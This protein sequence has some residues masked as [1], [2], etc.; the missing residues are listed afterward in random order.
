MECLTWSRIK[1]ILQQ[2]FNFNKKSHPLVRIGSGIIISSIGAGGISWAIGLDNIPEKYKIFGLIEISLS[3]DSIGTYLSIAGFLVGLL[4][5]IIGLMLIKKGARSTS[6]VLIVSMLGESAHFPDSILQESEKLDIRETIKL[7]L[8]EGENYIEQSIQMFNAEKMVDIYH[9]FILHGDCKKVLLGGRARVPFLVAYGSCFKSISAKVEYFD[10]LHSDNKWYFLDD[11]NENITPEYQSYNN[12]KP[13]AAG[14]IGLVIAFTSNVE[15]H[16]LPLELQDHTLFISS[17][18]GCRR[19]L[20]KNE[21]NLLEISSK[22]KHIIDDLSAKEGCI[23]IHLFLSIQ[24]SLALELGKNY[25][26]GTHKNWVI[27]NF[28]ASAGQY[29][30]AIELLRD[31]RIIKYTADE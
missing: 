15:S 14:D 13:N 3:N 29:L 24:A 18:I 5:V 30:W 16:Q 25:Q 31:G 21:E 12:L 9:R 17:S 6:R 4:L 20:I 2:I 7:G 22:I 1:W 11:E 19:N 28:D 26:E 23:K 27:H 8:K 10:Q